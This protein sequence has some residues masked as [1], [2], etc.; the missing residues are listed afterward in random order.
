[1]V[2][3]EDQRAAPRGIKC[4]CTCSWLRMG[5]AMSG[6]L[7]LT[8]SNSMPRAG[9]GVRMSE[10]KMTPS[11]LKARQH[12]VQQAAS[13]CGLQATEFKSA[14]ESIGAETASL[15]CRESSM[16]ISGVSER[17]RK[18]YL[19]EYLHPV[20]GMK[21]DSLAPEMARMALLAC[22]SHSGMQAAGL[23][24]PLSEGCHVPPCLPHQPHWCTLCHCGAKIWIGK[25]SKP[26]SL[27]SKRDVRTQACL[28]PSP[29]ATRSI[30][31]S[32]FPALHTMALLLLL[33]L[34]HVDCAAPATCW[35]SAC[36]ILS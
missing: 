3:R 24:H 32:F 17:M 33:P 35:L 20:K 31:G 34:A 28:S 27:C 29:R 15:T 5:S 13:P 7:P 12:C 26:S 22:M 25:R 23:L 18:E 2:I 30:N 6:P 14:A 21:G 8:M 1:M 9:R 16:A 11:G 19:S 4:S 10:K 36:C